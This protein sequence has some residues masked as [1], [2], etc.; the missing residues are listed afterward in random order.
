MIIGVL[1]VHLQQVVIDVLNRDFRIHA[2]QRHRLQ[3]Q[4]HQRAGGVLRQSLINLQPDLFAGLHVTVHQ[5]RGDQFLRNIHDSS[6]QVS[7]TNC[8]CVAHVLA[9]FRGQAHFRRLMHI[10]VLCQDLESGLWNWGCVPLASPVRVGNTRQYTTLMYTGTANS[11]PKLKLD[12]APV[13]IIGPK[14]SRTPDS[15]TVACASQ[16]PMG[17]RNSRTVDELATH[18]SAIEGATY[19]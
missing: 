18:F 3:L 14:M 4:H 19:R 5:M 10:L 7:D 6:K 13:P 8:Q 1:K 9:R 2:V 16:V 11:T 12:T 17:L 15:W